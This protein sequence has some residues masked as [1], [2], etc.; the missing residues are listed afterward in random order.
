MGRGR[1]PLRERSGRELTRSKFV[2]RSSNTPIDPG[3][4]REQVDHVS[5]R[6]PGQGEIVSSDGNFCG[7][8][9][10]AVG[11]RFVERVRAIVTG[12]EGNARLTFCASTESAT[13]MD[14]NQAN[15][16]RTVKVRSLL[17]QPRHLEESATRDVDLTFD[18]SVR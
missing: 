1:S 2:L 16:C 15:D 18:E 17:S 4:S 11:E 6:E 12:H 9:G 5:C 10:A 3:T 8:G 14:P 13:P 7:L